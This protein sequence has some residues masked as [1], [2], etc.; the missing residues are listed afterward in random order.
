MGLHASTFLSTDINSASAATAAAQSI[1]DAFAQ[2]PLRV[3]VVYASVNHDQPAILRA[4]RSTLGKVIPIVGCSVQGAAAEG[5][6]LEEGYLL[7]VMGL[8]GSSLEVAV[9]VER[10]LQSDARAQ[11]QSLAKQIRACLLGEPVVTVLLYDPLCNADVER[12]IHGFNDE[13]DCPLIGGGAGQPFGPISRTFQYWQDE[14]LGHGAVAL[15]LSGPFSQEIGVCH[16]TSPTGLDMVVTRTDGNCLIE[17]DGRPAAEVWQEVIGCSLDE[18]GNQE[19]V[20]NWAIGIQRAVPSS[21]GGQELLYFV[22]AAFG[23]DAKRGGLVVQAAIPEGTRI[24]LHHRTSRAVVEGTAAMA[25]DLAARLKGRRPW[26]VMG[27]EC[28]ARTSPF[29]GEAETL[30]ENLTL[31]RDVAPDVPWLGMMAWGEIA[32]VGGKPAFHNYTY[33]LLVLAT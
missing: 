10:D 3:V 16:G 8:G 14:V 33:P 25:R 23:F 19:F 11:G 32:P 20:S 29:L 18:I 22:R 12:L 9:A 2:H 26:A 4:I 17:I 30:K 28:G 7:G 15:A 6:V 1:A 21:S 27:F 13:I 24:M 5:R 31:Q